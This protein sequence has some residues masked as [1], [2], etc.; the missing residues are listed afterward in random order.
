MM[1]AHWYRGK[2]PT[3]VPKAGMAMERAWQRSA[4]SSALRVALAMALALVCR[5][6]PITAAWITQRALRS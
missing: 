2:P 4:Q 5:S 1:L 3:P 6:A